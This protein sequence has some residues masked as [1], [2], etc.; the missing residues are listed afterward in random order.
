MPEIKN[1]F[2]Q[3]KM[4][5]DLD[6]RLLP[7]GQYR[8]ALNI[9]VSTSEGSDVGTVQNVLGN[10]RID[11]LHG[12][13][14]FQCIGSIVDEKNNTLYWFVTNPTDGI[15]GI[16]EYKKNH[17]PVP[18]FIDTKVGTSDAVLKFTNKQITGI[19]IIDDFLFWTDG[20]NE[21]KKINISRCKQGTSGDLQTGSH[22]KLIVNN[23]V[24]VKRVHKNA[25]GATVNSISAEITNFTNIHIGTKLVSIAGVTVDSEVIALNTN[26]Q[27]VSFT[28]PVSWADGDDLVFTNELDI[29][30]K[31]ITVIKKKP[32][33]PPNIKIY[34]T[35]SLTKPSLFEKTLC[36]IACRYKYQ[37]GEYS[38]FGPFTDII[39]NPLYPKTTQSGGGQ[40]QLDQNTHFGGVTQAGVKEPYNQAMLSSIEAID[41]LDFVAPDMPEDVVQID[42][43][44]KQEN[45]PIV[46]SIDSI[47]NTDEGWNAEGSFE[48][49]PITT[50]LSDYK[51]VYKISSQNIYAALPENQLL[52]PWDN[53]PRKALAQEVSGSRIIY[54]N[55]V[56]NY[57]LGISGRSG[58][59]PEPQLPIT[60]GVVIN[61][62]D[63]PDKSI[64]WQ[65]VNS[66]FSLQPIDNTWGGVPSLKSQ[67]NYQLGVV[68][69]DYYGRET[70]VYTSPEAAIKIPWEKGGLLSASQS[71]QLT[72]HLTDTIPQWADYYKYYIKETSNEYYNLI[73]DRAYSPTSVLP[74]EGEDTNHLWLSFSSSDRNKVQ[75]DDY[76]ILKFKKGAGQ[77]PIEN[78]FKVIDIK[79][80]PPDAIKYKF[81]T[82]GTHSN[83]NFGGTYDGVLDGY[84]GAS[85]TFVASTGLYENIANRMDVVGNDLIQ[86]SKSLFENDA[87]GKGA[88]LMINDDAVGDVENLFISWADRGAGGL[89]SMRYQISN[90]RISN[91]TEYLLK[92]SETIKQEDADIALHP[93]NANAQLAEALEVRIQRKDLKDMDEF[94]GRFF[95]KVVADSRS[96]SLQNDLN[97]Q[98]ADTSAV[99]T[100]QPCLW[101]ADPGTSGF[102]PTVGIVN[103]TTSPTLPSAANTVANITGGSGPTD[104]VAEW[105]SLYTY[106]VNNKKRFFIDDMHFVATMPSWHSGG[107]LTRFAVDALQGNKTVYSELEW[108]NANYGPSTLTW[109][110]QGSSYPNGSVDITKNYFPRVSVRHSTTQGFHV[111]S[112]NNQDP[113]D[114]VN[115]YSSVNE[116]TSRWWPLSSDSR[117]GF[118]VS[119]GGSTGTGGLPAT[120]TP[121]G[122]PAWR[123]SSKTYS[124]YNTSGPPSYWENIQEVVMAL[125]APAATTVI[126]KTR[127][128]NGLEGIIETTTA[129]ADVHTSVDCIRDW[130]D[131]GDPNTGSYEEDR[132]YGTTPGKFYLHLSFMGPGADLNPDDWNINKLDNVERMGFN[133]LGRPA[134]GILQGIHGGGVFTKEDRS[135]F[136][137]TNERV[138]E[139][140]GHYTTENE[141]WTNPTPPSV[142]NGQGYHSASCAHPSGSGTS[143]YQELHNK[144]WDIS[145]PLDENGDIEKFK[146]QIDTLSRFKFSNDPNHEEFEILSVKMRKLYNHTPWKRRFVWNDTNQAFE[147]GGDSVEEAAVAWALDPTDTT[148]KENFK[149]K[150]KDFAKP[151]NRRVVYILELNKDP[152]TANVSF[153]PCDGDNFITATSS[154]NIQ[155]LQDDPRILSGRVSSVPAVWETEPKQSSDLDIYYEASRNIP[156]KITDENREVFAPAGCKVKMVS[157][158]N[159]TN[160]SVFIDEDQVYLEKWSSFENG[161]TF[162]LNPGFN[163][164][165]AN[166]N[167]INYSGQQIRFYR[168]DG[169][170]TT[171]RVDAATMT[172]D[173]GPTY[174]TTFV[175]DSTT[176]PVMKTGLSWYNCFSF[177]NGIESDRV[178]DDYNEMQINNG[179]KASSTTEEPYEEEH[180]KSGLIFSGLYNSNSGV[181]NLNQFIMAEK[182]TKDLNPTYGSIQKLFSRNTDLVTFCEDRVVKIL[183]NKDAVFNADGNPQLTANI[184]VLGQTVPFVGDYGISQNPESFAQESYRAYFTDKNRG[185][186]LRLSK[187]GLTPI[188]D[189]GMHDW[190]RDNLTEA[191]VILGTY[192]NFKQNYNVTLK[193]GIPENLLINADISLGQVVTQ[194]MQGPQNIIE[195]S[196]LSG[197][198]LDYS[199]VFPFNPS[200]ASNTA[201]T[202]TKNQHLYTN[203]TI[204]EFQGIYKGAFQE[205]ISNGTV[206][207][208]GS[209]NQSSQQPIFSTPNNLLW[210]WY[211]G[212][213]PFSSWAGTPETA[214]IHR[215]L[216]GVHYTNSGNSSDFGDTLIPTSSGGSTGGTYYNWWWQNNTINFASTNQLNMPNWTKSFIVPPAQY[217]NG[218]NNANNGPS[219]IV[220]ASVSNVFPTDSSGNPITNRTV[221]NGEE[222][223]IQFDMGV[224]QNASALPAGQAFW[225]AD[226]IA[227]QIRVH[228]GPPSS[229]NQGTLVHNANLASPSG[230]NGAWNSTTP[231]GNPYSD[232]GTPTSIINSTLDPG[233]SDVGYLNFF[234]GGSAAVTPAISTLAG[235]PGTFETRTFRGVMKFDTGLDVDM[236]VVDQL[237]ITIAPVMVGG[238]LGHCRIGN[239]KINKTYKVEEF[240]VPEVIYNGPSMPAIPNHHIKPWAEVVFDTED[241]SIPKTAQGGGVVRAT[242]DSNMLT[243]T[244]RVTPVW[245]QAG[246]GIQNK[247]KGG[248]PVDYYDFVSNPGNYPDASYFKADGKDVD[249]TIGSPTFG[250]VIPNGKVYY[251]HEDASNTSQAGGW[252]VPISGAESL[253]A[254]QTW[255]SLQVPTGATNSYV[256]P[257]KVYNYFAGTTPS[258]YGVNISA[259][260]QPATETST[261]HTQTSINENLFIDCT[262]ALNGEQKILQTLDIDMVVGDWYCVDIPYSGT[263]QGVNGGLPQIRVQGVLDTGLASGLHEWDSGYPSQ[264]LGVTGGSANRRDI[265][266]ATYEP[267]LD[268]AS[269]TNNLIIRENY[270]S[271][272]QKI[273][274]AVFKLDANSKVNTNGTLNTL[275]IVFK[276]FKGTV[277]SIWFNNISTTP[278]AGNASNW[279]IPGH[280]WTGN[281]GTSLNDYQHS[282]SH[283]KVYYL[284]GQ[285]NWNITNNNSFM[286]NSQPVGSN[287]TV[288]QNFNHANNALDPPQ[289]TVDGWELNFQVTEA[290]HHIT[291]NTL[292]INGSLGLQIYNDIGDFAAG[293][294]AGVI[295]EGI[296]DIGT[297]A[298]EFNMDNNPSSWNAFINTGSGNTPYSMATFSAPTGAATTAANPHDKIYFHPLNS[299]FTGGIKNI[300]LKNLTNFFSG[301]AVYAWSFSGFDTL[302]QNFITWDNTTNPNNP[303]ILFNDAPYVDISGGGPIQLHQDIPQIL[304]LGETYLVSFDYNITADSVL[305]IYYF[306]SLGQGFRI[307]DIV[308][309]GTSQNFNTEVEIGIP[310]NPQV[311]SELTNTFVVFVDEPLSSGQTMS[312]TID[313]F[314]LQQII[315]FNPQTVSYSESVRGWVSFKSFIPE[316]GESMSKRYYTIDSGQL[317]EHHVEVFDST[318]GLETN[319]NTFYGISYESNITALLNQLPSVIKTFHTINY[320]GSQ[321][322]INEFETDSVTGLSTIRDYNFESKNGWEVEILRTDK[323]EGNINEFIEKEGKWFNYVRG[324]NVN[325]DTP[326]TSEFSFQGLGTAIN[327]DTSTRN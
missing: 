168:D 15:D 207:Q 103:K 258:G 224:M 136:G 139:C 158:S 268:T 134:H 39:F 196:S 112:L 66:A 212:N 121:N 310:D 215:Y 164:N 133:N 16:L 70:P 246:Y 79:N 233:Y 77:F 94:S 45:S 62:E 146:Q 289:V 223:T 298:I 108:T 260:L 137:N 167:E 30:E 32:T 180:R 135:P 178:L 320:E 179:A 322:K 49:T 44:Y 58:P 256:N 40:I 147:Y 14:N 283:P 191:G 169:S 82:M 265:I 278:T 91:G 175:I 138:I 183:S 67:R 181:N 293:E 131:I 276:D 43:L 301:G 302:T 201:Y 319:R 5:K 205:E 113:T 100:Q 90:I 186:V 120:Q 241:W 159:A 155:F 153:N 34:T 177:G 228:D 184:N 75:E 249:L 154:G 2:I 266:C 226:S 292:P 264:H 305:G 324:R 263:A 76:L 236:I 4:N 173:T 119:T 149:Q 217:Q 122:V 304:N 85:A 96:R 262:G 288:T 252:T 105:E 52:R 71:Y 280:R 140:E 13:S 25:V 230:I 239:F 64:M 182:I 117:Y 219:T 209:G 61:Y 12:G 11:D 313:N 271:P 174:R 10:V 118:D 26:T 281:A 282:F 300:Y 53:V 3:G 277:N 151:S 221:F 229:D 231:T 295:V 296:Q 19:N 24:V 128:V 59:W 317:W 144:Q 308:G 253:T 318:S 1:T 210:Q 309:T 240:Y 72:A 172:Y 206:I 284:D 244:G 48:F 286:W 185:A 55:Y 259:V 270:S 36:R 132:T 261:G 74:G 54:G 81:V 225:Q 235:T 142:G 107:N 56:Q 325:L 269:N 157:L 104:T 165:D 18:I 60:P 97:Q 188:S 299:N 9:Q 88:A 248:A 114:I 28:D 315:H 84:T 194:S 145:W 148:K 214:K 195:N 162:I 23:D 22:T 89:V 116:G 130:R 31:H 222:I 111:S 323:E 98:I 6:E 123:E 35:E 243:A 27:E 163:V 87:D 216:N 69:G 187:D 42:F 267:D 311:S 50:T 68:F 38:A 110:N 321:S 170:Y 63:R 208:V 316:S 237:Y 287:F 8:D 232:Q 33:S 285:Y 189:H 51:G 200:V 57:N 312:G 86:L 20:V 190:F 227:F 220:P 294:K 102:D 251:W 211:G 101:W 193:G 307:T 274:R 197:F 297:Y 290:K 234:G 160:G 199:N 109:N 202:G 80:E 218:F 306:N 152:R 213:N 78:R 303:S 257:D 255:H 129:Y 93:T 204:T 272:G 115:S 326:D 46:Y 238:I 65:D 156:I 37:D 242:V 273:Y 29:Q 176:D 92:L 17:T 127:Y 125:T 192:D 99:I 171:S 279:P 41:I 166:G 250:Q 198:D 126:G 245:A 141:M 275:E 143:T 83:N 254:G 314:V 95:V 47:K 291:G 161:R 124:G 7:N 21:P 73:M 327:V 106:A 150:I 203:V 247:R